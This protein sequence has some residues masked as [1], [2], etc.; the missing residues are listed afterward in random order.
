MFPTTGNSWTSAKPA[1]N[2]KSAFHPDTDCFPEFAN[3]FDTV[4]MPSQQEVRGRLDCR[5]DNLNYIKS[6]LPMTH[7]PLESFY[8]QMATRQWRGAQPS[9]RP[10]GFGIHGVALA[11]QIFAKGLSPIGA[12]RDMVPNPM[13]ADNSRPRMP[14]GF[15]TDWNVIPGL[16]R[17]NA[18]AFRGDK[19]H[20]RQIRLADGFH[21]PCS[22]RDAAYVRLIAQYFAGYMKSRFNK[23]VDPQEVEQ[24]ILG[25]GQA[26]NVFVE[27]EVW[28]EILKGE[29][30]HLGRM[31]ANEFLKGYVSTSRRVE[32][33]AF[34]ASAHSADGQK[35]KISCVYALHTEGGFLLPRLGTNPHGTGEAEI[36]HPGTLAWTKVKAFRLLSP[37]SMEDSRTWRTKEYV[38]QDRIFVRKGFF[39][40]DPEG[41][42]QVVLALGVVGVT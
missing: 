6:A 13:M 16:E 28:R 2:N 11:P 22:R 27:Y 18:Y 26:G 31:V 17:V 5:V 36:A 9:V 39:A 30:L 34:F 15:A 19:R 10:A 3:E 37:G 1:A 23:V 7:V 32:N 35:G 4:P 12:R 33:A 41:A 25:R 29:E 20:P 38:A 21:P 14:G 24:Y 40:E 8:Q 42:R